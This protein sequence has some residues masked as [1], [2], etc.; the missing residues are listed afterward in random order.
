MPTDLTGGRPPALMSS[1]RPCMPSPGLNRRGR[2]AVGTAECRTGACRDPAVGPRIRGFDRQIPAFARGLRSRPA[3][4]PADAAAA[5]PNHPDESPMAPGIS[6]PG[7]AAGGSGPSRRCRTTAWHA[8]DEGS[9][10]ARTHSSR[11]RHRILSVDID[12][13]SGASRGTTGSDVTPSGR[14]SPWNPDADPPLATNIRCPIRPWARPSR[15][16]PKT[17]RP[18]CPTEDGPAQPCQPTVRHL[19]ETPRDDCRSE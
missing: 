3:G 12:L 11:R 6:R 19:I 4:H 17:A 5:P 13:A 8:P 1:A 9:R 2:R 16:R 18:K 10:G 15:I 14:E 7:A